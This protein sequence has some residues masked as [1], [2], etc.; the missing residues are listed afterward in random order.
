M[1]LTDSQPR[2]SPLLPVLNRPCHRKGAFLPVCHQCLQSVIKT[3]SYFSSESL[4]TNCADGR[5]LR[6]PSSTLTHGDFC[7][8]TGV[9]TKLPTD[10]DLLADVFLILSQSAFS[11]QYSREAGDKGRKILGNVQCLEQV[12]RTRNM[13]ITSSFTVCVVVEC[14]GFLLWSS[15]PSWEAEIRCL[16]RLLSYYGL[17]ETS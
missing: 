2:T 7:G 1:W 16:S 6:T 3:V 15:F 10:Q 17:C 11:F 8:K 14:F 13:F 5:R 9:E 12:S 4:L